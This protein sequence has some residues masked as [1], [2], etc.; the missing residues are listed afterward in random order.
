MNPLYYKNPFLANRVFTSEEAAQ[1]RLLPRLVTSAEV[2]A[3]DAERAN[4]LV[5]GELSQYADIKVQDVTE[6]DDQTCQ[7][8]DLSLKKFPEKMKQI[9]DYLTHTEFID[10]IIVLPNMFFS[11]SI[12]ASR[13]KGFTNRPFES[14]DPKFE[15]IRMVNRRTIVEKLKSQ[16]NRCC[17]LY[18]PEGCGKSFVLIQLV[19]ELIKEGHFVVFINNAANLLN[20]IVDIL[21]VKLRSIP[22]ADGSMITE[23]QKA[24]ANPL[25]SDDKQEEKITW[26]FI[27]Q[28]QET[29][30][31]I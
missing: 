9:Q 14:H 13:F 1:R 17:M 8:A 30:K 24:I 22:N 4:E 21:A 15:Y 29:I 3:G 6:V 27:L 10:D 31:V 7:L 11:I 28:S 16:R 26:K 25:V 2:G 23:I 18:G 5:Q 19:A 12:S 20:D